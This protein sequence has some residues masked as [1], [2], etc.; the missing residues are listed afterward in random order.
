MYSIL[1]RFFW[2]PS[3]IDEEKGGIQELINGPCLLFFPL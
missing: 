1:N 2:T 3:K